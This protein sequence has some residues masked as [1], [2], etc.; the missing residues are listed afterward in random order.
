[1]LEATDAAEK[2]EV[3]IGDESGDLHLRECSLVMTTYGAPGFTGTVGTIG[4]TRMPYPQVV[5][6]LRYVS[7]LAGLAVAR[8]YQ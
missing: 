6:R 4:P 8:L 2:V 5:A 3:L 7:E 1:M